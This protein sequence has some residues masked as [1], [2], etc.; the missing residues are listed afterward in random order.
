MMG[1]RTVAETAGEAEGTM[2][3]GTAMAEVDK[4]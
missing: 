2:D 1:E 4:G 3:V